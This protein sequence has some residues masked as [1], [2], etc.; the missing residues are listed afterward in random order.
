MIERES[1]CGVPALSLGEA[2][3][4]AKRGGNGSKY[5]NYYLQNEFPSFVFHF[6]Q[7]DKLTSSFSASL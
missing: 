7:V 6:I 5:R 1:L 4:H 2:R 3:S